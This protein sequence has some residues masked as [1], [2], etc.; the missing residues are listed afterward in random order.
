MLCLILI[1]KPGAVEYL[2][3]LTTCSQVGRT[4]WRKVRVCS[5]CLKGFT[6]F[7]TEP[8]PNINL[9]N[10]GFDGAFLRSMYQNVPQP[11]IIKTGVLN[12]RTQGSCI[13][14]SARFGDNFT[15]FRLS[16]F[17]WMLMMMSN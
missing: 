17:D 5:L 8:Q 12:C 15:E 10:F 16:G 13:S 2:D 4:V 3:E 11:R 7:V 6:L 9:E 1:F 14:V